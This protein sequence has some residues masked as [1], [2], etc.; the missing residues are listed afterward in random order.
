MKREN[1]RQIPQERTFQVLI[2]PSV[3]QKVYCSLHLSPGKVRKNSRDLYAQNEL[4]RHAASCKFH[5]LITAS[6]MKFEHV[7]KPVQMALLQHALDSAIFEK[8][9][10]F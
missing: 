7:S 5:L 8:V 1:C 10:E 3:N 6:S 2:V 4:L 9:Q